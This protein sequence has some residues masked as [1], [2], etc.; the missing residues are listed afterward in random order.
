MHSFWDKLKR[1]PERALKTIQAGRLRGMTDI[2]PQWRYEVMTEVFGPIG[3][4]WKYE[5]VRFWTEPASANQVLAFCQINLYV[6]VDSWSDAIPGIGGSML[7][8]SEKNGLHS[9]DEAYKM[10]LTD[11]LS[12]AMKQLGVAADIYAGLWDGSKY[13]DEPQE[14]KKESAPRL[15]KLTE[16][17]AAHEYNKWEQV[18]SILVDEDGDPDQERIVEEWK[19][20]PS[21]VRSAIK[22][23]GEAMKLSTQH[24]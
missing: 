14:Q 21:N 19:K 18:K 2:S 22:A 1:P 20:L 3:I 7:I 24:A 4:G 9:S 16:E 15:P 13:R 5:I 23:H 11:A 17:E 12:V 6:K 10:A 8:A